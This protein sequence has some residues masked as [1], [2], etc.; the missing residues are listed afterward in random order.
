MHAAEVFSVSKPSAWRALVETWQRPFKDKPHDDDNDDDDDDNSPSTERATA[1]NWSE[2]EQNEDE[3]VG[4]LGDVV[5]DDV[6]ED[7]RKRVPVFE[8]LDVSDGVHPAEY[9]HGGRHLAV[10]VMAGAVNVQHVPVSASRTDA[11][12]MGSSADAE[13][14]RHASS[15]AQDTTIRVG[16]D[17]QVAR[18][19]TYHVMCPFP[20]YVALCDH[21][22]PTLHTDLA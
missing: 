20:L 10:Q 21:S 5:R 6:L 17:V 14:A 4:E 7:A 18:T 15:V 13:V 11:C 22:L 3:D 9:E 19:P 8:Q 12:H 2:P 1:C 16:F